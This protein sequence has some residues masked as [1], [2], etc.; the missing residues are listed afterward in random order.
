M[1][2][3]SKKD[4]FL[5]IIILLLLSYS[6]HILVISFELIVKTFLVGKKFKVLVEEVSL[7]NVD[8]EAFIYL[9]YN[10]CNP[11]SI[12]LRILSI[13]CIIYSDGNYIWT[14]TER[15]FISSF[16]LSNRTIIKVIFFQIPKNKLNK[17][18]N[19]ICIKT[20]ILCEVMDPRPRRFIVLFSQKL[21]IKTG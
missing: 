16:I 19:R 12:R 15:Y 20:Y 7:R 9:S 4:L 18:S 5:S 14:H 6:V 11:I 8:D 21:P 2:K 1:A 17:I 13:Q 3:F 10:L